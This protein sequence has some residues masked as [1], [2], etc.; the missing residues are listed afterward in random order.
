[1][2]HIDLT[3]K[4]NDNYI[5]DSHDENLSNLSVLF[6]AMSTNH[7]HADIGNKQRS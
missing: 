2:L 3:K 5:L 1:M 4:L 6:S 7:K